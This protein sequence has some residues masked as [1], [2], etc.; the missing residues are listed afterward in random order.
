MSKFSF[1]AASVFLLLN[2]QNFS[3]SEF[4]FGIVCLEIFFDILT[5]DLVWYFECTHMKRSKQ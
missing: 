5:S 3:N 2:K 1:Q 4:P